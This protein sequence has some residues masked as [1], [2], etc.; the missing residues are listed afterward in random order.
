MNDNQALTAYSSSEKVNAE[1]PESKGPWST[2]NVFGAVC[3]KQ[4]PTSSSRHANTLFPPCRAPIRT[5]LDHVWNGQASAA[6]RCS[7]KSNGAQPWSLCSVV[8][9]QLPR[10]PELEGPG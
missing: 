10:L 8:T 9:M 5:T 3:F 1:D 6:H 4:A 7:K 2:F